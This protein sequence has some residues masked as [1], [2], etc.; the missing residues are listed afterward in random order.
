MLKVRLS[1]ISIGALLLAAGAA[2]AAGTYPTSVPDVP[3]AWYAE[4]IQ[5]TVGA[6][7]VSAQP[8][9]PSEAREHGTAH[10]N[11]AEAPLLRATPGF[12]H[13]SAAFPT[14]VNDTGPVL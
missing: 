5:Y 11:Y 4:S 9:F 6:T 7:V 1:T 3:A 14:S 10:E 8:V 2:Q 12:A 13:S